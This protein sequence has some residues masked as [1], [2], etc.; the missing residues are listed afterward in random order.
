MNKA[1]KI[2]LRQEAQKRLVDNPQDPLHDITHHYRVWLLAQDLIKEERLEKDIDLDTLELVC[3]WHDVHV[4]EEEMSKEERIVDATSRYVLN[5]FPDE[6]KDESSLAIKNHEFG[7][8]P[9]STIGK[10][11][12]DVDK[13]EILSEQRVNNALEALEAGSL[14]KKYLL[15]LLKS[16]RK[17]WLPKMPERYHFEFS[18]KFHDNNLN[19]F[20]VVLKNTE[21]MII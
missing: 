6:I 10:I 2:K 1:I 7:S 11:L 20:L 14:D 12:Q 13:L 4:I 5:N 21:D 15:N 16:I 8:N 3:W 19:G 17:D 9:K 18:K